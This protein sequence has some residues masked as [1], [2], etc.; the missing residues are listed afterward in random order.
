MMEI[1][2]PQITTEE[3]D[4]KNHAK[5]VVEPLER[6][7]GCT[8]GNALRRTLLSDLPGFAAV[9]IKIDGVN[10][11]FS[12]IPGVREDVVEIILNIKNIVF[13]ANT[14]DKNFRKTLTLNKYDAGVVTAGDIA[15]DAEIEVVNPDQ[16]LCTLDEGGKIEM[17]I[18]VA[19][20]RGYVVADENKSAKD[21]IGYIAIDSIFTPVVSANCIVESAR[22]GN[23]IDYDKLTVEVVT[24]K[25]F[26]AT[27]VVSLA[28]KAVCEHINL[29]VSLD[30]Y[31][32]EGNILITPAGEGTKRVL[33]KSIED[34]ELSVRSY[35]CL[36]RAGIHTVEDLTKKS[37]DD[38]LKVR[39]LGRKSLDEVI[40]KLEELGLSL[41]NKDE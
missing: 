32:S 16:Y 11:E 22:V 23:R 38:M 19:A 7:F 36:K 9:G 1:T 2:T 25:A 20:G 5:I 15:T 27:E 12:T 34:L 29:F 26:K 17:E 31:G 4:A 35:N 13:K 28:A 10:H 18:T 30:R 6:G 24:N 3:N 37:E 33:E 14:D 21:P 40:K 8:L 41:K 39:N